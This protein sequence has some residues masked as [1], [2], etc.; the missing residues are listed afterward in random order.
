M[1]KKRLN[2]QILFVISAVVKFPK[3]PFV[4]ALLSHPKAYLEMI[5]TR[6]GRLKKQKVRPK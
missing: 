1:E 6:K 4:R 3:N 5:R 2:I